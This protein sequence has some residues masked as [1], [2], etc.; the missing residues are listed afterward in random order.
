[1]SFQVLSGPVIIACAQIL[2]VGWETPGSSLR[3]DLAAK[4]MMAIV[5]AAG[6]L[7]AR[8]RT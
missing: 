7:S 2:Q 8:S 1:M 4:G 5:F 3:T 6:L